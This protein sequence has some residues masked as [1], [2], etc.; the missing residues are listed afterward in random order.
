MICDFESPRGNK[1]QNIIQNY[2]L[3]QANIKNDLKAFSKIQNMND[4][5]IENIYAVREV[6]KKQLQR[7]RMMNKLRHRYVNSGKAVF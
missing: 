6:F 7:T 1:Q 2:I 5:S 3:G 4:N